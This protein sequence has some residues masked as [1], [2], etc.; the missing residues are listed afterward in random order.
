MG[1]K[2]MRKVLGSGSDSRIHMIQVPFWRDNDVIITQLN[3]LFW[4]LLVAMV[5]EQNFAGTTPVQDKTP[6]DGFVVTKD[7]KNE[8]ML[9]ASF[10]GTGY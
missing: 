4:A 5:T 6:G 1:N 9:C 3:Q 8:S 2:G 7:H 10:C